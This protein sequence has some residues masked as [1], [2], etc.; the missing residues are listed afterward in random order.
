[1]GRALGSG[2]TRGSGK[3]RLDPCYILVVRRR[4]ILH[5]K[6]RDLVSRRVVQAS[7]EQCVFRYPNAPTDQ[8]GSHLAVIQNGSGDPRVCLA[9]VAP[10]GAAIQT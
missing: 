5:V 10:T 2:Q 7:H 6:E 8:P 9:R 1:M 4:Q 3:P